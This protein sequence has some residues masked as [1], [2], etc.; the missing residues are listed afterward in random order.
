MKK[1][2]AK[3]QSE[4]AATCLIHAATCLIHVNQDAPE[5]A[6]LRP[7]VSL[8]LENLEEALS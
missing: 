8:T 5:K 7:T 4:S 1:M 3:L 6:V 2:T